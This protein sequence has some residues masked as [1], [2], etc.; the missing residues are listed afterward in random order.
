MTQTYTRLGLPVNVRKLMKILFRFTLTIPL[1][2]PLSKR[3]RGIKED[4]KT[5]S[6]KRIQDFGKSS[7]MYPINIQ[8]FMRNEDGRG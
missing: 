2:R 7:K 4:Y 5:R 6:A 8:V 3:K 1:A